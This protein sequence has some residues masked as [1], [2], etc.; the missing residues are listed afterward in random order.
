M[1]VLLV[2]QYLANSNCIKVNS[3]NT[4]VYSP[5]SVSCFLQEGCR[6]CLGISLWGTP[7]ILI[8]DSQTEQLN[9]TT[10]VIHP[11]GVIFVNH[12]HNM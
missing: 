12:Q 6:Q 11:Y 8:A 10:P 9:E 5:L 4:D 1:R 3:L 7:F 2:S